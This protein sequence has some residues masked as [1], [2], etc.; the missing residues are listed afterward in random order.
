MTEHDAPDADSPEPESPPAE[1]AAA[2]VG[3]APAAP[4][5]DRGQLAWPLGWGAPPPAWTPEP[6]PAAPSMA[7]RRPVLIAG[8]AMLAIGIAAGATATAVMGKNGNNGTT[9]TSVLVNDQPLSG[10]GGDAVQVASQ[11]APAVGTIISLNPGRSQGDAL[12]SGFVI[13]INGNTSYLLTNNHVVTGA[14]DLHVLMPSGQNL[15]ATVVGNDPF[16]DLAVVSVDAVVTDLKGQPVAAVFARS[17]DL[18]VGQRVVAIG[19]PLGNQGS[20]TEGVISALHRTI[21]AGDSQGGASETLQDVLQTDASINPGNSGGPL[22]DTDGR[23]VGVNVAIAGQGTNI[24]FSI[25]SDLAQS[26]AQSL[27][28]HEKVHHPF[29]GVRYLD[30]IAATEAGR[31][32][33][34]PGVLV[35]DVQ[36]GSPAGGAGFKADDIITAVDGQPI[37]NGQTLGGLVQRHHVGDKVPFTVKRGSQTLTLSV[38]LVDRPN[39]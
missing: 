35:T 1:P 18:Q 17:A 8:A 21:Q 3:S 6:S 28:Q 24:G 34:G 13:S 26:V 12:G 27:I 38:T 22:A 16:D 37:D 39:T 10:G 30:A 31:G 19:S 7:S 23:V 9:T 33:N 29:L 15:K 4:A 14:T 11:L 36:D 32:F 20:V 2:P 5:G 25:P